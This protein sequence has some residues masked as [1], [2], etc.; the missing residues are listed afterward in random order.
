MRNVVVISHV[1]PNSFLPKY[2]KRKATL[3]GGI[4]SLRVA[5]KIKLAF[6][7]KL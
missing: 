3:R 6:K 2:L 1:A 4:P 5:W 7:V